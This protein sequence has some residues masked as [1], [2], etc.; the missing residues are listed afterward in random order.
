MKN[1]DSTKSEEQKVEVPDADT[2]VQ[3]VQ[4][5]LDEERSKWQSQLQTQE[6]NLE[7]ERYHKSVILNKQRQREWH[8]TIVLVLVA[9]LSAGFALAIA[10]QDRTASI[11]AANSSGA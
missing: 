11:A 2:I 10:R 3:A 8:Q 9:I 6:I 4:R 7:I 1:D 5:A